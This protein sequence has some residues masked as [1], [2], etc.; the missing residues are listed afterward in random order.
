LSRSDQPDR[1]TDVRLAAVEIL[2]RV[3]RAG[4]WASRLLE[5]HERTF[6]DRRDRALLHETV[7]GVLRSR[8]LLDAVLTH[9]SDRPLAKLDGLVRATLRVG[10]Y[11]LLLLDRVP[12]H[13]AVGTA[14]ESIR[15]KRPRAVGYVNGVL[16]KVAR[17]GAGWLPTRPVGRSVAAWAEWTSHPDWWVERVVERCGWA[18]AIALLEANNR[19]ARTTLHPNPARASTERLAAALSEKGCRTRPGKILG[20]SLRVFSGS[21]GDALAKGQCWVQDEASQLVALLAAAGPGMLVLDACAAPGGKT[22]QLASRVGPSGRVVAVD[23]HAGRMRRLV[24]NVERC[25]FARVSPVIADMTA[26]APFGKPFDRILIDA[27]CSG[28]G[29][30]RRHPEIRWRLTPEAIRLVA[31]RQGRLLDRAAG[32]LAD[33]GRLVYSVCSLEPE[34]GVQV[35][36][37]FLERNPEFS[38]VDPT[39]DLP[40]T[41][42]PRVGPDRYL[43]TDPAADELDGFFGAVLERR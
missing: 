37:S 15:R 30:L 21:P 20:E 24:S 25:G 35:I 8:R 3:E 23:R 5:T 17:Q 4:A 13:A 32:L 18:T 11:S 19:P 9:A 7:L 22:M 33:G 27:P 39:P 29:T 2:D 42:R 14:V 31:E 34:E 1:S 38:A 41:A 6:A 16:R 28:T 26:P 40:A 12:D 10:T 43:R 36:A